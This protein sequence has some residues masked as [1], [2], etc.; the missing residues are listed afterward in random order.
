MVFTGSKHPQH[1]QRHV[2][3]TCLLGFIAKKRTSWSLGPPS[4]RGSGRAA[5]SMFG[6]VLPPS[7]P[8]R[9]QEIGTLS[10]L[11]K[12]RDMREPGGSA[13]FILNFFFNHCLFSC[14][15][16]HKGE[17]TC[18]VSIC[19]CGDPPSLPCFHTSF[20]SSS[21]SAHPSFS[22]NEFI[23]NCIVLSISA[24]SFEPPLFSHSNTSARLHRPGSSTIHV[25]L[26]LFLIQSTN[27]KRK[28]FSQ[29]NGLSRRVYHI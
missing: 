2:D 24:L 18:C 29:E 1:G 16:N 3:R 20:K 14:V 8:C 12:V 23:P 19:L 25:W 13:L 21:S 6:I 17:N 11:V 28:L 7:R 4:K 15:A 26:P 9:P 22:A 10:V 5:D 27:T